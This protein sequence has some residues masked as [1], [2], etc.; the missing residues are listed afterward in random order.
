MSDAN[1]L[2]DLAAPDPLRRRDAVERLAFGGAPL[3]AA[4]IVAVIACLATPEKA[5][6]RGAADLLARVAPSDRPLVVERLRGGLA[7]DDPSLRWGAAYAFGRLGLAEPAMIAPLIE[8]LGANDGDQRWAAADLLIACARVHRADVL[9]AVLAG[10]N[11]GEPDRRKMVLYVLRDVAPTEPAA[12]AA[13]VRALG[14]AA[15][16]VR[17]AA[18]AALVRLEPRPVDAWKLV[19]ALVRNDPDAGVRRAAIAALG[20][21]G[22]GVSAVDAV[23]ADAE[24]SDDPGVRRAAALARR[25]LA[26]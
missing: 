9:A 25:R 18:L 12:H 21:G 14:D 20:A 8:A 23:L 22:R 11:D 24:T 4:T 5:V 6:Q 26:G 1:V 19:D 13:T 16:G 7:A 15:V 17:L 2:A 3:D 10:T